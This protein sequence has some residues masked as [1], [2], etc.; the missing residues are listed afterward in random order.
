MKW[1]KCVVV[2]AC[3][4]WLTGCANFRVGENGVL[5]YH[6]FL[7]IMN[8]QNPDG[9]PWAVPP[10]VANTAAITLEDLLVGGS[11]TGLVTMVAG[12]FGYTGVMRPRR[13][14]KEREFTDTI[15]EIVNG[16]GGSTP[17]TVPTVPPD[18]TP[19]GP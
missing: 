11:L 16:N 15:R 13:K 9:T 18:V 17:P 14:R 4:V 2:V 5:S 19:A 3:A 1:F 8:A 7:H 10:E 12:Y 6:Q